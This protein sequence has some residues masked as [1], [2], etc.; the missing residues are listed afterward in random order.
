[1]AS[2]L[3]FP[4]DR[5]AFVYT[6]PGQPIL[7]PESNPLVIY[8]DQACTLLADIYLPGVGR[9]VNSTI[10]T[11]DAGLVPEF[12][13]PTDVTRLYAKP[14]D[15]APVPIDAAFGPRIDTLTA[16]VGSIGGSGTTGGILSGVGVPDP[17]LGFEGEFYIDT[18]AHVI[19]GPKT[20]DAWGAG[21]SMI[22]PSGTGASS[23]THSQFASASTWLITH[24]LPFVPSVTIVDSGGSQVYGDV[25][26]LSP[27]QIQVD[28]SA[29]FSGSAFLS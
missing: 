3:L 5:T 19:Y 18:A 13:G 14:T 16:T 7:V 17:T 29:P 15:G 6:G 27:S 8:L 9:I 20:N 1:M 21:T 28:F 23:Y 12:L 24:P 4:S 26:V 2:R 11:D 25:K 22:G 10:Y